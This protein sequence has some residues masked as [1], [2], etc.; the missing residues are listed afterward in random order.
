VSSWRSSTL[1]L[2][3]L[4]AAVLA[5]ASTTSAQVP[6]KFTNLKVLPKD[7][8]RDQLVQTMRSFANALGVRCSHCHANTS[9]E[10]FKTF[11]FASDD[12]ETKRVARTM[13]RMTREINVHL[14]PET[15]R[16]PLRTVECMTCHHGLARPEQLVDVLDA[17]LQKDGVEAALKKY[18]ELREKYYGQ[19]AYDFS[20]R[21][22]NMLAEKLDDGKNVDGAIAVQE[23][24]VKVNPGIASSH[25]LLA[26]LY[27]EKGDRA[28]AR[29]NFEKAVALA[30]DDA[31]YKR[32]LQEMSASPSPR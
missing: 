4:T 19:A 11:D 24:N 13:M 12:K 27:L 14:L 5:A 25:R 30:P 3:V 28:A 16:S 7:I 1:P 10:D 26:D 20:M 15:E 9:P 31:Y 8:T 2:V 22:L 6:E 18:G 23:F 29:A 17:T 21:S 32:R